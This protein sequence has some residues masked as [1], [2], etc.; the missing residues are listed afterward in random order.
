VPDPRGDIFG[1][2]DA[3]RIFWHASLVGALWALVVY[4]AAAEGRLARILFASPA[5]TFLGTVSYSLYLWHSSVFALAQHVG[6]TRWAPAASLPML[7]I[8]LIPVVLLVAWVSF[9]CTERPFLVTEPA[10]HQRMDRAA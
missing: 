9:R 4:G 1:N 8:L 7:M 2:A 5:M 3:P 6:L 10:A